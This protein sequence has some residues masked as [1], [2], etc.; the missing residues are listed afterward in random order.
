MIFCDFLFDNSNCNYF[1]ELVTFCNDHKYRVL[2]C[3]PNAA[4]VIASEQGFESM[5]TFIK[6]H[7]GKKVYIPVKKDKFNFKY[8]CSFE[9]K[10][11]DYLYS[12]TDSRGFVDMPSVWGVYTSVRRAAI[13]EDIFSG[14]SNNYIAKRFGVTDRGI[15]KMKQSQHSIIATTISE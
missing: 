10:H 4:G 7:G 15:R 11:F 3:L 14:K 12:F 13:L 2:S 1:T 9:K 8:K 6:K 5:F